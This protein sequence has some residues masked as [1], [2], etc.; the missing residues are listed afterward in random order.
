MDQGRQEG[1]EQDSRRGKDS[2]RVS[3]ATFRSFERH[4]FIPGVA[5]CL[6]SMIFLIH[7][8]C[9]L[10]AFMQSPQLPS[11]LYAVELCGRVTSLALE[12][13]C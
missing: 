9:D 12:D 13:I 1:A 4:H 8:V 11:L 5:N 6:V 10:N 3:T 7:V 2:F